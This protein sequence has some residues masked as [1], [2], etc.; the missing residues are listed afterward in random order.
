MSSGAVNQHSVNLRSSVPCPG[1]SVHG[2]SSPSIVGG[3]A[4]AFSS[5]SPASI[6]VFH[7]PSPIVCRVAPVPVDTAH[8]SSSVVQPAPLSAV[9]IHSPSLRLSPFSLVPV[10]VAPHSSPSGPSALVSGGGY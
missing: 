5:T 8:V 4:T 1:A 7:S 6:G 3:P 2:P 10:A 9:S